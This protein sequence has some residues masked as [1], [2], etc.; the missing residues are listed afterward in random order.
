M[1]RTISC[2]LDTSASYA[3][4]RSEMGIQSAFHIVNGIAFGMEASGICDSILSS[5]S[6]SFTEARQWLMLAAA[7]TMPW[8]T[9]EDAASDSRYAGTKAR[10]CFIKSAPG[11]GDL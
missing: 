6:H 8:I 5:S 10:K 9:E 1:A 2:P 4:I 7:F 11:P 3:A